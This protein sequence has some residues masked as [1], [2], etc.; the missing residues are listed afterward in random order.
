MAVLFDFLD[1]DLSHGLDVKRTQV[2]KQ[3]VAVVPGTV[4]SVFVANKLENVWAFLVRKVQIILLNSVVLGKCT[5][6]RPMRL[7]N[8]WGCIVG[9]FSLSWARR[10]MSSTA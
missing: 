3:K 10:T 6:R 1:D 5:C 8:I 9:V 4:G 7:V 2:D